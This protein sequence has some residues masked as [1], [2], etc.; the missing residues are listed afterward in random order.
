[1]VVYTHTIDRKMFKRKFATTQNYAT[2]DKSF[3]RKQAVFWNIL[4]EKK[5]SHLFK[6]ARTHLFSCIWLYLVRLWVH[7]LFLPYRLMQQPMGNYLKLLQKIYS[8][9][10][11]CSID[12]AV[13]KIL[14]ILGQFNKIW[15]PLKSVLLSPVMNWK[16]NSIT[17]GF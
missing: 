6:T 9:G 8:P 13:S 3:R 4:A 16:K 10:K 5:C 12:I 14:F 15:E 17:L 1:M 2:F 11:C 7:T